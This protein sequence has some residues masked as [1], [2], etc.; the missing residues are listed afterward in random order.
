MFRGSSLVVGALAIPCDPAGGGA[1]AGGGTT[2]GGATGGAPAG[3]GS[4]CCCPWP[5]MFSGGVGRSISMLSGLL[6]SGSSSSS[7]VDSSLSAR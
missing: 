1:G 2:G 4:C 3:G 6:G 5:S 7:G